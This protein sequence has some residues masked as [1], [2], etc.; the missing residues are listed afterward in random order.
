MPW[1]GVGVHLQNPLG[2]Q[3]I[4]SQH[5]RQSRL[6]YKIVF[7]SVLEPGSSRSDVTGL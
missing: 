3:G 2:G 6:K 7:L 4:C 5:P 1:E